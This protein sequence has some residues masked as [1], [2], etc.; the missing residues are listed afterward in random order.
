MF[1]LVKTC[2]CSPE[3]YDVLVGEHKVGYIRCRWGQV[4]VECPYVGGE[5]V[6]KAITEGY[7][8]FTDDERDMHLDAALKAI[9]VWHER[10]NYRHKTL[11]KL[12]RSFDHTVDVI[13]EYLYGCNVD[14]EVLQSAADLLDK[15]MDKYDEQL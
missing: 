1:K 3:Q 6:Y 11:H 12:V 10:E 9:K 2:N 13:H 7:G 4:T 5:M 14:D 8:S 15:L